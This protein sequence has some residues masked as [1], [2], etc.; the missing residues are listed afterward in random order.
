[1][2]FRSANAF[3]NAL[4]RFAVMARSI[5]EQQGARLPGARRLTLR[6]KAERDGLAVSD[7]LIKEIEAL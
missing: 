1:M 2:L 5:E 7:A 4:P 6:Q 3:A